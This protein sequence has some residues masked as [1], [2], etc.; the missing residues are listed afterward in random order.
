[1]YAR[2]ARWEGADAEA[3]RQAVDEIKSHDGPPE[4]VP[5]KGILVLTDPD[6]GRVEVI[7]LYDSEEDRQRGH[8]TFEGMSP[9]GDAFGRRVAVEM[10]E[11][12]F[13]ARAQGAEP[14][15]G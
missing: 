14:L 4:G 11:V 13:D 8:E 9:P 3:T 1:M 15:V 7:T 6:G 2:V 12:G 5:A 10:Y